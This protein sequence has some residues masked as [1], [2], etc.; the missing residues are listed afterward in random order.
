[1]IYFIYRVNIF[2]KIDDVVVIWYF[3]LMSV[4]G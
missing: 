2:G 1:M 4:K 3:I